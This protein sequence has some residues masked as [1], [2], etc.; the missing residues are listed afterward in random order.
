MDAHA[1]STQ[2][3][4]F[5]SKCYYAISTI[6]QKC[7]I[8]NEC[9]KRFSFTFQIYSL[10]LIC[11]LV[12]YCFNKISGASILTFSTCFCIVHYFYCRKFILNFLLYFFCFAFLSQWLAKHSNYLWTCYMKMEIVFLMNF[13][14]NSRRQGRSS[15]YKIYVF[16]MVICYVCNLLASFQS[17]LFHTHTY[18]K[19]KLYLHL[20]NNASFVITS[21]KFFATRIFSKF[22]F[23]NYYYM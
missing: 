9:E 4:A 22:I 13:I 11:M 21:T 14:R 17:L 2:H 20:R 7:I 3:T 10:D 16:N 8:F 1:Q 23:F 15:S 5:M 19:N 18:E 12:V 6:E